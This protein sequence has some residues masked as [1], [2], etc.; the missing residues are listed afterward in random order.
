MEASGQLPSLPPPLKSGPGICA[1]T[2]LSGIQFN[3]AGGS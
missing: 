3:L 1:F 2:K